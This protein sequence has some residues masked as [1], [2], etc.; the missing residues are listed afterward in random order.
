MADNDTKKSDGLSPEELDSQEVSNLPNREAMSMITPDPVTP[1]PIDDG[2][3]PLDQHLD[4]KYIGPPII[5]P[6]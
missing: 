3:P 4:P 1:G 5:K 6:T 2:F